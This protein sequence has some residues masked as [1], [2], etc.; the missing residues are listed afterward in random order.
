MT[1]ARLIE[2][3]ITRKLLRRRE[4][5]AVTGSST[6]TP[7][8]RWQGDIQPWVDRVIAILAATTGLL[9]LGSLVEELLWAVL[10]AST[11]FT[12]R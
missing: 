6:H 4:R 11:V 12:L 8:M 1:T 5:E 10:A 9:V 2:S 7:P 3:G